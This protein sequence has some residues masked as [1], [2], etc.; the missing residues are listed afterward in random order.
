MANV[1]PKRKKL[2]EV[3]LE[4]QQMIQNQQKHINALRQE[5][6]ERNKESAQE[7][8]LE[9]DAEEDEKQPRAQQQEKKEKQDLEQQPASRHNLRIEAKLPLPPTFDGSNKTSVNTWLFEMEQYF[10]VANLP[11]EQ[12]VSWG[13]VLLREGAANWWSSELQTRKQDIQGNSL[14]AATSETP[15]TSDMFT[16]AEF[17]ALCRKRFAPV[18]AAMTARSVLMTLQ[19]LKHTGIE[20]YN[21]AFQRQLSLITDMNVADQLVYYQRGLKPDVGRDVNIANPKTLIEAMGIASR[22]SATWVTKMQANSSSMAH[23]SHGPEDGSAAEMN[24][25]MSTAD[26]LGGLSNNSSHM[27]TNSSLNYIGGYGGRGGGGYRRGSYSYP[28]SRPADLDRLQAENRCFRCGQQGHLAR[29]CKRSSSSSSFG[30]GWN[31]R[32]GDGRFQPYQPSYGRGNFRGR[33]RGLNFRA[34]SQ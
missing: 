22:S 32:G 17:Q 8:D 12:R 33:G 7:R 23:S 31:S 29:D 6:E 10:Q 14:T 3:I 2:K 28:R 4:M 11:P 25:L 30:G 16:W 26:N 5:R 27:Y 19:Q 15:R 18:E 20:A 24:Y 9:A 13:A 34:R 21:Q 1:D